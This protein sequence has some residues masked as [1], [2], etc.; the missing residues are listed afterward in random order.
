MLPSKLHLSFASKLK[1]TLDND[2]PIYDRNVA[3]ILGLPKQAGNIHEKKLENRLHIYAEL[4]ERF[5]TLLLNK[6]IAAMLKK[7]RKPLALRVLDWQDD[8]VSDTKLL[9]SILWAL[10]TVIIKNKLI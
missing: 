1:H 3:E 6:Q 7:N 4:K 9:D 8:L 10:H 2:L 5:H